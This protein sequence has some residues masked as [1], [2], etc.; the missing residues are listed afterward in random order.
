MKQYS[1]FFIRPMHV[2]EFD[3]TQYKDMKIDFSLNNSM[4]YAKL[5][6]SCFSHHVE[7]YV[8]LKR[9]SPEL[10]FKDDYNDDHFFFQE[11]NITSYFIHN[12]YRPPSLLNYNLKSEDKKK[13]FSIFQ[14]REMKKAEQG[15]RGTSYFSAF[16]FTKEVTHKA[17]QVEDIKKKNLGNKGSYVRF[18]IGDIG[19]GKSTL[20]SYIYR[21]IK[22]NPDKY[23]SA[24]AIIPV[25]IDIDLGKNSYREPSERIS[26]YIYEDLYKK[27]FEEA[28][29]FFDNREF[30]YGSSDDIMAFREILSKRDQSQYIYKEKLF[31]LCL[32]LAKNY[33]RVFFIL[34]NLDKFHYYYAR[35]AFFS[36]GSKKVDETV[37]QLEDLIN[38]FRTDKGKET[39]SMAGVNVLFVMRSY[40]YDYINLKPPQATQNS[41]DIPA[42]EIIPEVFDNIIESRAEL[43]QNA[44]EIVNNHTHDA[45]GLGELYIT[46][47]DKIKGHKKGSVFEKIVKSS[48]HGNRSL[49]N[50][51]SSLS[52]DVRD[53]LLF[54]RFFE[55]QTHTLLMLYFLKG[56]RRYSQ[57]ANHFPNIFLNDCVISKPNQVEEYNMDAHKP[58]KHTYWL[59]YFI[60]KFIVRNDKRKVTTYDIV[61]K[62]KQYY[63]GEE[64]LI[65]HILGSLCTANEFRCAEFPFER[66]TGVTQDAIPIKATQRGR[67][68]FEKKEFGSHAGVEFCFDLSYLR[69]IIDDYWMSYPIDYIGDIYNKD[70]DYE[71][72]FN[73]SSYKDYSKDALKVLESD[74]KSVLLFLKLLDESLIHEMKAKDGFAEFLEKYDLIPNITLSQSYVLETVD[75]IYSKLVASNNT[76]ELV[77]FDS[78]RAKWNIERNNLKYSKFFKDYYDAGAPNVSPS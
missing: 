59:K 50:F 31:E 6:K 46:A 48:H 38:E 7:P 34:D 72:I 35:Y 76:E 77:K 78:I 42:Y 40:I 67:Q 21:D 36:S 32:F 68:L 55:K 8:D 13:I 53:K 33:G 28:K 9:E 27:T 61:S 17:F 25:Y 64:H 26:D 49:I 2:Y 19:I 71:H 10:H 60:L 66:D 47:L 73:T 74:G 29:D 3:I 20:V 43:L 63:P 58:H 75:N 45:E 70:L 56:K 62:F 22:R 4:S 52:I 12:Q 44:L 15:D 1:D 51:I 11:N 37:K 57:N 5:F 16:E 39:L 65:R 54:E 69:L 24:I 14:S 18:L 30:K 23:D 41:V